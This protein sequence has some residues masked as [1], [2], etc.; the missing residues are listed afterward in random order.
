MAGLVLRF[1]NL[2]G[3][4]LGGDELHGVRAA[5]ENTP[6]DILRHF[7]TADHSLPLS[8][9]FSVLARRGVVLDEMAFRSP[10]LTASA[11]L[12]LALPLLAARALGRPTAAVWTW[13]LAL[14]PGLVLYGRIARSYLPMVLMTSLALAAFA[15][16]WERRTPGRAAAFV[17]SA[18]LGVWLHLG[19]APIV[20]APFL[21]A[22]LDLLRHRP[23]GARR[24]LRDLAL[25]AGA[26]AAALAAFLVPA[27]PSVLALVAEKRQD[28]QVSA[29]AASAVVRWLA[30]TAS[31][32]LATAVALLAIGGLLVLARVRPRLA[33][34]LAT[35]AA[36]QTA[37]IL[38]LSPHGINFPI[39]LGRYLLP[40]APILLLGV[41][42]TFAPPS[43]AGKSGEPKGDEPKSDEPKSDEPKSGEPKGGAPSSLAPP[44]SLAGGLAAAAALLL[45]LGWTGPLRAP[46]FL[47][48]SFAHHNSFL[49]FSGRPLESAPD[50]PLA[51]Y[52][53]LPPGAVVE[54][55]WPTA[56]NLGRSLPA[57]QLRHGRRVLVSAAEGVPR[58]PRLRLRNEVPP[59]PDALLASPAVGVVAHRCLPCEE[60]RVRG[61]LAHRL[62]IPGESRRRL[63]RRGEEAAAALERAWGPPHRAAGTLVAWDLERLRRERGVGRA[64]AGAPR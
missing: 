51:V 45:A 34:L 25:L 15:A 55:P 11:L 59:R 58:D 8:A 52:A 16:W 13:L 22:L 23:A 43:A 10:S 29:R 41:A 30:G 36:A 26:L 54:V 44:G 62:R 42:C 4:V 28:V 19:A 50:A 39:V 20:A 33:G 7:S 40:V 6:T 49:A 47:R 27:L 18:A 2:R 31:A 61:G 3:Q 37:G 12:L 38:W 48:G 57:Y 64:P 56:W 60:E 46:S 9:L 24:A 21:F 5:I 17:A 63:V 1:W 35:A 32:P 14:S 53:A